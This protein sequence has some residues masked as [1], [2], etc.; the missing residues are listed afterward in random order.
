MTITPKENYL[1]MLN[2]EIPEYVPSSYDPYRN[3]VSEE[4]LTPNS[5]PEGI[6][7][8]SFGVEYVGCES[9]N[10]GAMPNPN[11]I[12]C[13]DITQW[14]KYIKKPDVSDRDWEG[15]YK[16]QESKWDR[17]NKALGVG[18]GDYWLTAV[19]FLGMQNTVLAMY[20]E[21]DALKEMLEYVSDFYIEVLKQQIYYT[22]PDIL[23]MMDDDA[24]Y[25]NPFFSL[26]MYREFFKPLQQ[27]H[28]DVAHDNGMLVVRHD[29][30]RCEPFVDDWVQM[31]VRAWG[32]AQVTNDLKGIKAKYGN[33]IAID[34]GWD[35]QGELG[36]GD[37][38]I[39]KLKDA[40]AEYVD[41]LAPGGGFVFGA[42]LNGD[43]ND[44]G[45]IERNQV[46]RDF[47]EDYVRNYYK[48]HHEA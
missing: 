27:R 28:I 1:R 30:G 37:V 46:I 3:M 29:C 44:P 17:V 8:S 45:V 9:M 14:D 19:S 18:G 5:A 10:M 15:Y 23:S 16:A 11:K 38:P 12:L 48:N 21:P 36:R 35:T 20:E 6:Y 42:H 47:Y 43:R 2:R 41:T 24:A 25:L 34:G 31:D 7:I 26:E 22:H 32:P 39:P 4:L 13:P 33:K 40:L